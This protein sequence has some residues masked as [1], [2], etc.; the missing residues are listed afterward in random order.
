MTL[1]VNATL[2]MFPLN[3]GLFLYYRW[4][5]ELNPYRKK[6]YMKKLVRQIQRMMDEKLSV[7]KDGTYHW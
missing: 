5:N 2:R 3:T 1:N 4:E 6:K 7:G